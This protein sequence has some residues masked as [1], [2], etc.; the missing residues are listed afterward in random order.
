MKRMNKNNMHDIQE[1]ENSEST[2]TGKVILQSFNQL[3]IYILKGNFGTCSI[4][5][6]PVFVF[7]SWLMIIC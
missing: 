7:H 4:V 6:M 3:W 2:M 5:Y 1:I